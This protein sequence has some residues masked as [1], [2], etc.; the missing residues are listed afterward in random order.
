M[1]IRSVSRPRI[2]PD[3]PA[4]RRNIRIMKATRLQHQRSARATPAHCAAL[5]GSGWRASAPRSWLAIRGRHI[6]D[7]N[8][9]TEFCQK[10]RRQ[11]DPGITAG[12]MEI[13]FNR[14]VRRCQEISSNRTAESPAGASSNRADALHQQ[15]SSDIEPPAHAAPSRQFL[16]SYFSAKP[17]GDCDVRA[18]VAR[19]RSSPSAPT[20]FSQYP[21]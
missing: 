19:F 11:R 13:S 5:F 3:R 16:L 7:R 18:I 14:R 4:Q 2:D 20:A 12:S 21:R 1:A 15:L 8:H 10:A 9:R 6:D 17:A